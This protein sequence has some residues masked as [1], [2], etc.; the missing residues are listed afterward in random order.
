LG[1]MANIAASQAENVIT[2][3]SETKLINAVKGLGEPADGN[4]GIGLEYFLNN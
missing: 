3:C 1:K 2:L 4:A